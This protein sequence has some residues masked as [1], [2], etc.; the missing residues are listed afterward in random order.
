MHERELFTRISR[1][2]RRAGADELLQRL[3]AEFW[4]CELD[5]LVGVEAWIFAESRLQ[6][7]VDWWKA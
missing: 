6:T 5:D 2:R 1:T 4:W 3:S 7:L